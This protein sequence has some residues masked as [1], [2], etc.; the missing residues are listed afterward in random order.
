[1]ELIQDKNSSSI[2]SLSTESGMAKGTQPEE[3]D[4]MI[5]PRCS[6]D[7]RLTF[8]SIGCVCVDCHIHTLVT[9]GHT[10]TGQSTF[11]LEHEVG[12]VLQN[13]NIVGEERHEL[14]KLRLMLMDINK[15]NAMF[16]P[17]ID[18]KCHCGVIHSRDYSYGPNAHTIP[19]EK[20]GFFCSNCSNDAHIF[21]P[22]GDRPAFKKSC[23]QY[24][25]LK[26]QHNDPFVKGWRATLKED[27]S[28]YRACLAEQEHEKL[29]YALAASEDRRCCPWKHWDSARRAEDHLISSQ[30]LARED[31]LSYKYTKDNWHL[32]ACHSEPVTK[33]DCDDM[34]CGEHSSD[35]M[36]WAYTARS[37]TVTKYEGTK[38][39]C[40][41]AAYWN[42]W[43]PYV[44]PKPVDHKPPSQNIM[45]HGTAKWNVT[46]EYTCYI[47]EK[48]RQCLGACCTNSLC[49][50]RYHKVCGQCM[51]DRGSV[52]SS[53]TIT[54]FTIL[55]DTGILSTLSTSKNDSTLR[56]KYN[57]TDIYFRYNTTQGCWKVIRTNDNQE[58]GRFNWSYFNGNDPYHRRRSHSN[59]DL[60]IDIHDRG[61]RVTIY[62]SEWL[63]CVIEE[64]VRRDNNRP[65]D[66]LLYT[67]NCVSNGHIMDFDGLDKFRS[68]LVYNTAIYRI[69]NF[70]KHC[71][72]KRWFDLIATQAHK[73]VEI[74][75]SAL[76]VVIT[77]FK[78]VRYKRWFTLVSEYAA[79]V[80]Q[81]Q[82]YK[83]A[84]KLTRFF[85]NNSIQNKVRAIKASYDYLASKRYL[86]VR[87]LPMTWIIVMAKNR[88]KNCDDC[89]CHFYQTRG[90]HTRCISCHKKHLH[91]NVDKYCKTCNVRFS[92]PREKSYYQ[93]CKPCQ[94]A[95]YA[96][97]DD[98]RRRT[99]R[100]NQ[101]A[102]VARVQ[103]RQD[104]NPATG[105]W[106]RVTARKYHQR[107]NTP[108]C[109]ICHSN[110]RIYV[111]QK[112][113][114][115][116]HCTRCRNTFEFTV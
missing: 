102:A 89:K 81:N 100:R 96:K 4:L 70:L 80:G 38:R 76:Q 31:A 15:K 65:H 71:R 22:I 59:M 9:K 5:G 32:V 54:T 92:V 115:V 21:D 14:R 6:L 18:T 48:K 16:D 29:A 55:S 28:A 66:A 75:K 35:K 103:A 43:T 8:L 101:A 17:I 112:T 94:R 51:V 110:G 88:V 68:D 25:D 37:G 10:G 73:Q 13:S 90:D 34:R 104:S 27:A 74:A 23:K 69:K 86:P 72:Y 53:Y 45:T 30:Y 95:Q 39:Y 24:D 64:T 82:R 2:Q 1:M 61:V 57:D 46:D 36:N 85:R 77:A 52:E 107:Q 33:T 12:K 20:C 87:H 3:C 106:S 114:G 58:I 40:G 26:N 99:Y 7:T 108:Q 78:R 111:S 116:A 79:Q 97:Q 113:P 56:G 93:N 11:D 47:C 91:T 84:K 109:N 63:D 49:R 62:E 105:N 83:A 42:F 50:H 19:C 98:A 67:Y 60:N 44:A 41:R